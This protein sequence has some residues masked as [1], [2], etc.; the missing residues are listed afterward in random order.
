MPETNHNGYVWELNVYC[1]FYSKSGEH[2]YS[3]W[4]CLRQTFW[5]GILIECI[6]DYRIEL[7]KTK[8]EF[9]NSHSQ[10][11]IEQINLN[12]RCVCLQSPA[13]LLRTSNL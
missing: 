13:C 9:G 7:V 2:R 3:H 6:N 12:L 5:R 4:H 8:H 10:R 11:I 1:T